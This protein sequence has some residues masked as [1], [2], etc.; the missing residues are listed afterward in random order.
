M[1]A[2]NVIFVPAGTTSA[3]IA[4]TPMM[5]VNVGTQ[6]QGGTVTVNVGPTQAGPWTALATTSTTRVAFLPH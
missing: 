3:A 6:V 1:A 5:T 2:T 4:V